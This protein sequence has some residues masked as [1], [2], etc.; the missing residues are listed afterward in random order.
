[1]TS[2]ECRVLVADDEYW[3]R[4]N[5]RTMLSAAA[6]PFRLLEPAEDG[7]E[8]AA[9]IERES[10]DILITDINMPH[11]DGN[12]LIRVAKRLRPQMQVIV[13][14]GYSD[15]EL[16]RQALLGGAL[17][18]LLKPVTQIALLEVLDKAVSV[19]NAARSEEKERAEL[20]RKVALAASVL[21]DERLSALV[22]DDSGD[23]PGPA[24][25]ADLELRFAAFTLI[26]VRL[27]DLLGRARRQASDRSDLERT[28]RETIAGRMSEGR[29]VV[30][31]NIYARCEFIVLTD[32]DTAAISRACRELAE[33]L[34][35]S[36]ASRVRIAVS[37]SYNSFHQL[38][39]A[40]HEARA[41][42]LTRPVGS[43]DALSWA[44]EAHGQVVQK[45]LSPETEKRLVFA[46][47]SGNRR[48]AREV[49][50]EESGLRGCERE[51]WLLIE[52]K[53]A[54]EYI[55]GAIIQRAARA[56]TTEA[57]LAMESISGLLGPALESEDVSEVCSLLEQLLEAALGEAG[58][59]GVSESAVQAAR[60][61]Q[62]Y[63]EEHYFE[64]LSLTSLAAQFGHERSHLSR[65]F[66]MVT[67]EHL[68]SAI[69]SRR[70]ERA[71]RY[72]REEDLSLTEIS[73]LVGYEEYAYF[74]RVFRKV[75][76]VSP[77]E[78]RA[79]VRAEAGK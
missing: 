43:A 11:V 50:F 73:F 75:M 23:P 4:E 20:L 59:A 38:R 66:S 27:P 58:P 26:L 22:S 33:K 56:A 14:S 64:P 60:K 76:G 48:L 71:A 49:A 1:M 21:R 32:L 18:Y 9:R 6:A 39:A 13:L 35:R 10:P 68:M 42:I 45:R 34:R 69:A 36:T 70:I 17:D 55:A 16:V 2:G 78:Y 44:E 47:E 24:A 19:M 5:I 63:I 61:V 37:G 52:L 7:R 12:E 62:R 74:N 40:Y 28:V 79:S 41:A 3:V 72:M 46:L 53:L 54:A 77:S 51:R 29:S 65:M 67:G 15:F 8:A 25:V 57:T 31:H 30:F